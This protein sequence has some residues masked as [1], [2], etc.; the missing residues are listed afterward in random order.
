MIPNF[1]YVV[2]LFLLFLLITFLYQRWKYKHLSEKDQFTG[3]YHKHWLNTNLV[4]LMK[5]AKSTNKTLGI[6]F[7]DLDDFKALN[8]SRGHDYGDYVLL[9]IVKTIRSAVGK[10]GKL[11]RYGGDEFVF[12]APDITE[13]N[14]SKILSLIQKSIR[15]TG[16]VTVSIGGTMFYPDEELNFSNLI[17]RADKAVYAAKGKGR[18]CIVMGHLASENF[19][20]NIINL[21]VEY[22]KE[23]SSEIQKNIRVVGVNK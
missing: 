1:H 15:N 5:K 22:K 16:L 2:E 23:N 12:I 19:H 17:S 10:T 11:V 20:K 8:D 3:T 6:A 18:N 14:F 4:N 9:S 21:A 13:E 7:I